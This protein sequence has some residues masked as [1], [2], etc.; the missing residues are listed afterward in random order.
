MLCQPI[1]MELLSQKT[2]TIGI[3]QSVVT[4]AIKIELAMAVEIATETVSDA[5][6]AVIDLAE[7]PTATKN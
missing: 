1:K 5:T 6:V 2:Q 7:R 4:V 3:N